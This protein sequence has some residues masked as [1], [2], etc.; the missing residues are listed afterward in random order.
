MVVS[1]SDDFCIT[2]AKDPRHTESESGEKQYGL[3]SS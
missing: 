1:H 3:S 2:I